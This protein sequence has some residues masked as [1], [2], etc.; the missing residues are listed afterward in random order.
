MGLTETITALVNE[1]MRQSAEHA[2]KEKTMTTT[3]TVSDSKGDLQAALDEAG[4]SYAKSW[5]R[6]KLV[7]ALP[8][9]VSSENGADDGQIHMS[10]GP[11]PTKFMTDAGYTPEKTSTSRGWFAI[12]PDKADSLLDRLAGEIES[13]KAE[14]NGVTARALGQAQDRISVRL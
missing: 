3:L 13:Q 9:P 10:F 5:N 2:E 14:G 6:T 1:G 12:D 7:A 8:A 11:I 4:I